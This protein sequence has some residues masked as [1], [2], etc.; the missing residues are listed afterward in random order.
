MKRSTKSIIEVSEGAI[1]DQIDYE[2]DKVVNNINDINTDEKPRKITVEITLTPTKQKKQMELKATVKSTLRPV[3]PVE[4]TLFNQQ[5]YN[6]TTKKTETS[7]Q[8][9]TDVAVGQINLSGDI[10]EAPAPIRIGNF[11]LE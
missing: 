8:E 5:Q 2:L 4:A 11:N 7:L 10:K 3:N 6:K 1:I 9:I